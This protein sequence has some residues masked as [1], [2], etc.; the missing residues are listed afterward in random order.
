MVQ[1]F[2][3]CSSGQIKSQYFS[4]QNLLQYLP[5]NFEL[6]KIAA[7]VHTANTIFKDNFMTYYRKIKERNQNFVNNQS[8]S[9]SIDLIDSL[10]DRIRASIKCDQTSLSY[11]EAVNALCT[12]SILGLSI[13]VL[14]GLVFGFVM[15]ILICVIPQMWRRMHT[16]ELYEY[17]NSNASGHMLSEEIHPFISSSAATAQIRTN[18]SA[19]RQFN[20]SPSFQRLAA[21]SSSTNSNLTNTINRNRYNTAS[22]SN[23]AAASTLG[24]NSNPYSQTLKMTNRLHNDY[25]LN[26]DP[27]SI[28]NNQNQVN[29]GLASAPSQSNSNGN[30]GNFNLNN[31]NYGIPNQMMQNNHFNSNTLKTNAIKYIINNSRYSVFV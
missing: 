30:Y 14:S 1:Y 10:I 13:V 25:M 8:F 29:M 15:P 11:R 19:A 6:N 2:T 28:L 20:E 22:R 7:K 5:F 18:I 27:Y 3:S 12:N 17:H 26:A 24:S 31:S 23:Y 4:K 9:S 16:K 21:N